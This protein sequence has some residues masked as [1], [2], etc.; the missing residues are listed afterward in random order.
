LLRALGFPPGKLPRLREQ[1]VG[2][3][4]GQ[5]LLGKASRYLI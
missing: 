5:R 4:Q 2:D 1:I 3:G